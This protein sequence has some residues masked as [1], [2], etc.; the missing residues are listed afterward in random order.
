MFVKKEQKYYIIRDSNLAPWKFVLEWIKSCGEER[1][2]AN[3]P[4][5][6]TPLTIANMQHQQTD[7]TIAHRDR[8]RRKRHPTLYRHHDRR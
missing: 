5:V 3:V 8:D 2:V 6:R 7:P 4:E 1:G